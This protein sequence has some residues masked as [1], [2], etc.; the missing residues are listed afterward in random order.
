MD[1]LAII[2]QI[3]GQVSRGSACEF[4]ADQQAGVTRL[5][6]RVSDRIAG[7]CRPALVANISQMRG[8][9]S[10]GSDGEYQ[11]HEQAGVEWLSWR[12]SGR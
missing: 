5:S 10:R 4:Q 2:S 9:V 12:V 6:L 8:Q 1:Y 7:R 3:S 11:A